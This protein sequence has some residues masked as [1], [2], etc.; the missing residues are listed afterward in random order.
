MAENEYMEGFLTGK[1]TGG[2]GMNWGGGCWIWILLIFLLFGG[3]N[4]GWGGMGGVNGALT[5]AEMADGFNVAG[6][7]NGQAALTRG[8]FDVQKEILQNRFDTA[9]GLCGVQRE[10]QANRFAAQQCCCDTQKEIL[11]NRYAMQLAMN[12]QQ[13]QLAQCCCD[14][15]TAVHAEGEATRALI[16]ANETQRLRDE[17]QAA[18]IQLGQLSQTQTLLGAINPTPR[19]AYPVPSPYESMMLGRTG[20]ACCNRN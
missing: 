19:P 9:N 10:I 7:Q 1:N 13:A 18:Q 5:R 16:T 2:D 11:E 17:L 3:M 20:A 15:K 6:L 12:N 8:Q 4:G 14:M